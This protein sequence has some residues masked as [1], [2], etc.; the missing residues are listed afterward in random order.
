[1]IEMDLKKNVMVEKH[2]ND[3]ETKG[4]KIE[5][6]KTKIEKDKGVRRGDRRSDVDVKSCRFRAAKQWR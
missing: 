5:K 1:M 2:R 4:E 3:R 6:K